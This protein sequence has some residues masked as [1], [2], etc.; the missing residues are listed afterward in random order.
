MDC[1]FITYRDLPELDPDDKLALEVLSSRGYKCQAAVWDD[2][3]VDW[4][5]AGVCVLRSTWDYHLK[6]NEFKTWLDSLV[7]K[8]TVV[9]HPAYLKW[10]MHKTYLAELEAAG[11]PIVPTVILR[12]TLEN[13]ERAHYA[14]PYTT[15]T[16]WEKSII[17]PAV[18]LATSGV[19]VMNQNN[20]DDACA[21]VEKLLETGDVLLQPFLES[22]NGYGER[23]LVFFNGEYSHSARKTAFQALAVAGGAGETFAEDVEEEI[24]VAKQ[25]A[26]QLPRLASH[27][28][29]PVYCRIDL[30]R[31]D[32]NEPVVLEV[33]LIEPTLFLSLYEPAARAFADAIEAVMAGSTS[34]TGIHS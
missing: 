17:K 25:V 11:L 27:T 30:V 32:R 19:M 5:N 29:P 31:N 7:A 12:R 15:G 20:V 21:H 16:T 10:S 4:E 3:K 6:L 28:V 23:S 1:T 2:P 18:G 8:T 9:N 26:A 33:E 24:A 14:R 34:R 13:G 22:V